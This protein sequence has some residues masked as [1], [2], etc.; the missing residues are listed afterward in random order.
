MNTNSITIPIFV[1][2]KIYK[3]KNLNDNTY[4]ILGK[5]T[6]E[7]ITMY[8]HGCVKNFY[9]DNNGQTNKFNI[10]FG[11]SMCSYKNEIEEA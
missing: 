11:H 10:G 3:Q 9:F 8:G 4:S 7:D 6:H 1:V 2:G 5:F